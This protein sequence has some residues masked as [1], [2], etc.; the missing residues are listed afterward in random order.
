[1]QSGVGDL[2]ICSQ[3]RVLVTRERLGPTDDPA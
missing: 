2:P 1:M 3:V